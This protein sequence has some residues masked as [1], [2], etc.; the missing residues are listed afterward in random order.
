MLEVKKFFFENSIRLCRLPS[1]ASHNLQPFDF[2]VFGALKTVY[3]EQ[4]EQL[5]RG[6]ANTAGKQ[7][8]TLLYS[9][10]RDLAFSPR[11]NKS[12]WSKTGLFPFNPDKD[13]GEIQ[14]LE[15]EMIIPQTANVTTDFCSRVDTM[16]TPVTYES[17]TH[18]PSTAKECIQQI[19]VALSWQ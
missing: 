10:A 18:I 19:L 3:R 14:K 2:D 9:R 12:G 15:A 7:Y 6:G 8:F 13:F 16:H 5:Y 1:H 4:V 11:N 17:L